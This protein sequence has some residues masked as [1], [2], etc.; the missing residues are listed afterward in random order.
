MK[1]HKKKQFIVAILAASIIFLGG[2]LSGALQQKKEPTNGIAEKGHCY[3]APD[4][5]A[6]LHGERSCRSLKKS[7]NISYLTVHRAMQLGKGKRWKDWCKF[8][9]KDRK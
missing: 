1:R 3:I 6:K 5:G 7:K 9:A 4:G 8:C 2:P